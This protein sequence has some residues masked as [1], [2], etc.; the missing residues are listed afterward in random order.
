MER[1]EGRA[2][3]VRLTGITPIERWLRIREC[4]RAEARRTAAPAS[5]TELPPSDHKERPVG[6]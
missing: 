5:V 1:P 3:P 4:R 6:M 2:G